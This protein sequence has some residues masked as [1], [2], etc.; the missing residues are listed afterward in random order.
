[1]RPNLVL[2]GFMGTGKTTVGRLCARTLGFRFRD[3]DALVERWCGKSVSRIFEEHGEPFFRDQE[4]AAIRTLCRRTEQVIATGGGAVLRGENVGNLR[5]R[6]I[7]ILLEASE[8]E[9]L[10]RVSRHDS[11][12]LVAG[13][14]P[15][16]RIRE[17]LATREPLYRAVA[18]ASVCSEGL[19]PAETAARVVAAYHARADF[20]PPV[21]ARFTGT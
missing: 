6:G 3:S 18:D 11:R 12:P 1:M 2:I 20:W 13:E 17:L 16:G 21:S 7:V 5:S 19:P 15:A 14:D 10:K 9:I 8:E 4:A